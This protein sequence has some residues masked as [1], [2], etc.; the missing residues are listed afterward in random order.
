MSHI[1]ICMKEIHSD[2]RKYQESALTNKKKNENS[3]TYFVDTEM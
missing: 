2:Y 3:F 1:L